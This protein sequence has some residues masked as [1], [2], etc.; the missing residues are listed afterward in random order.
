L[1]PYRSQLDTE[2]F[3]TL[4]QYQ[5]NAALMVGI[6]AVMLLGGG[7]SQPGAWGDY[8]P[9][10]S[11]L[12][13]ARLAPWSLP[14]AMGFLLAFRAGVID[15]SIW[16]VMGL[17]GLVATAAMR[18]GAGATAALAVAGG[19]GLAVGGANAVLCH[20][21]KRFHRRIPAVLITAVLGAAILIVVN[22]AV[23]RQSL[24]VPAD[25]FDEGV[26]RLAQV[27]AA[28]TGTAQEDIA[29]PLTTLRMLLCGLGWAA[30]LVALLAAR[31]WKLA[32]R[33]RPGGRRGLALTAS[34]LLAGVS[35]YAWL[36]DSAA[37]PVPTRLI[38]GLTIPAAVVLAGGVVFRGRTMLVGVLLPVAM[39]LTSLWRQGVMPMRA[40]GYALNLLA[41]M[42]VAMTFQAA[43]LH[44]SDTRLA[45]I[46]GRLAVLLAAAAALATAAT[47]WWGY[48]PPSNL[49]LIAGLCWVLAMGGIGVC[50]V[51]AYRTGPLKERES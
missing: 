34:G 33:L 50:G 12:L 30:V 10:S 6:G 1:S 39:L 2:E 3:R 22:L 23:T 8:G 4:R 17:T 37:A 15:L 36:M 11:A 13:I 14:A 19:M 46:G 41:L 47:S 27:L 32:G 7:D 48:D 31:S 29:S 21:A 49:L 26:L 16:A 42:A 51:H 28:A 25:A 18:A 24:A 35:G 20:L 5:Y 40:D 9:E 45:R 44:R 43:V 38:D